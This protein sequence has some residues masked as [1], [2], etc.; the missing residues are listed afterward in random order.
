MATLRDRLSALLRYRVGKYDS[1]SLPNDLG[2]YGTT[3]S[4]ANI[5]ENT[6]MTIATV[7][8]CTYRIASSIASLGL[9]VFEREGRE[10]NPAYAHPA[11]DLIKYKPNDYQTA[12]EFWETIISNAVLNGRVCTN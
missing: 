5:N 12:F 8:A 1:Q 2:I 7:Y 9:D 6:A 10:V 4:G 11:F 3:T